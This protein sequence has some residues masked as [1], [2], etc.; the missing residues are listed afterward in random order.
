MKR[1]FFLNRFFA[2]DYSATSQILG[3]IA[4]HLAGTGHDVHVVTSRQIYDNPQAQL[5]AQEFINGVH[6]HRVRATRF[7]RAKLIGRA[8]DYISYYILSWW[9]LRS[10]VKGGDTVVAMTDPPLISV[11][12]MLVAKRRGAHLINWLQD[13]YPEIASELGVPFVKGP[14]A[15]TISNVRNRSLDYARM[16]VVVGQR[17]AERVASFKIP[18]QRIRIIHNW[19]D[20]DQVVPI[21]PKT[22]L[23]VENGDYTITLFLAILAI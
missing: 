13:I 6:V 1:I 19:S 23:C 4:T 16:N 3:D 14:V 5:S 10:L 15:R 17:M 11:V 20:D 2:P 18:P 22:T 12:A 8:I 21:A 9:T 7:G